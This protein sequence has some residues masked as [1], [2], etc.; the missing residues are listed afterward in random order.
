M[1]P[2]LECGSLAAALHRERSGTG[3]TYVGRPLTNL[4]QQRFQLRPRVRVAFSCRR[5]NSR[6]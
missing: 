1:I 4:R 6:R 5:R 3:A 2:A